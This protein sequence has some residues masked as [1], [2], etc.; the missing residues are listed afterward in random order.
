MKPSIFGPRVAPT[1][2]AFTIAPLELVAAWPA[3]CRRRRR[4]RARARPR[5]RRRRRAARPRAA[6]PASTLYCLPPVWMTAYMAREIPRIVPEEPV[7]SSRSTCSSDSSRTKPRPWQVGQVS[8]N[9]STRPSEIRLRV[10][11]TRPSSDISNAWVRVLSRA[12]A[13]RNTRIDLVAVRLDLHVDEVDHDD[14]ADVA[15]PEL[16][17]DL[18][19]RLEVVAEDR[20]LEVRLR[21]RSCR[22]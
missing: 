4:G 12:S 16:A 3:R 8:L 5:R 21:R 19:G 22:C 10:I 7:N 11:S 14:P 9:D 18:L 20:L 2:L 6:R 13:S 15:E 17:G 1:T